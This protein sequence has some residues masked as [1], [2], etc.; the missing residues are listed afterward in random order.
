MNWDN[1]RE[2]LPSPISDPV[3]ELRSNPEGEKKKKK[4]GFRSDPNLSHDRMVWPLIS[5]S[6]AL[7]EKK[8]KRK[9]GKRRKGSTYLG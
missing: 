1:F 6:P 7:E 5:R 3:D 9:K 4:A 2:H 8:K